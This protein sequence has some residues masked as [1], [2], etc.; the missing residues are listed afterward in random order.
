MPERAQLCSPVHHAGGGTGPPRHPPWQQKQSQARGDAGGRL[1]SCCNVCP[2]LPG[3]CVLSRHILVRGES[4]QGVKLG[5]TLWHVP[6]CPWWSCPT[7]AES[8]TAAAPP[9]Q[10]PPEFQQQLQLESWDLPWGRQGLEDPLSHLLPGPGEKRCHFSS[11]FSLLLVF[12]SQIPPFLHINDQLLDVPSNNYLAPPLP[13][14]YKML[15]FTHHQITSIFL[16][17]PLQTLPWLRCLPKV[18]QQLSAY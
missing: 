3:G 8:Q 7:L 17:N 4:A 10:S 5:R 1:L 12:T 18:R 15:L 9:A 11:L 14:S 6:A 13:S 16:L 2:P